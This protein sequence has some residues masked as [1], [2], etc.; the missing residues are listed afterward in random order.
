ML[1]KK[2]KDKSG[3][4]LDNNKMP[5]LLD[6]A[7]FAVQEAYKT[8]RTN[9]TFSLPGNGCKCFG[10]VSAS[11][12]DGKSTI[13]SNLAISLR[14]INKRVVLIDCDMRLP[15]IAKKFGVRASTG[16]SNLLS[17]DT[18]TIPLIRDAERGVDI[19]PA[20]TIPPDPTVLIS[21]DV[22]KMLVEQLKRKYDY[23]IFDF[24]PIN[25][26][27]D[28]VMLSNLIDGYLLVVR[29]QR[30]EYQLVAEAIRLM[31]LA[32]AR[33]IGCAY[34]GKYE[35]RSYYKSNRY[36]RYKYGKSY[37]YGKDYS[38]TAAEIQDIAQSAPGQGG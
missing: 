33:I 3:V 9:I 5:P 16:L 14:Q 24:P 17:G 23:V 18:T 8:L 35:E 19:I 38:K 20:G 30:S 28:A 37:Y 25:I 32:D 36:G 31:R 29:H 2:G 27:S 21:S 7:P 15:T 22:M 12:G 1:M 4:F 34:N 10:V 26:V 6:K 11:R 13:A